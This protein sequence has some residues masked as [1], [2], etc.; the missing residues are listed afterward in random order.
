MRIQRSR[1]RG[2][3]SIVMESD[4]LRAVLL[5]DIGG[6][7]AS[8]LD[9]ETG[10]EYLWQEKTNRL[11]TPEY[12]TPFEEWAMFGFDEMFP[13]ISECHYEKKPWQ[14][15]KLP[16]HGEVWS[17]AWDYEIHEDLLHMWVYGVRLPYR[18]DKWIRFTDSRVIRTDYKAA[19]P[20]NFGFQFIW[21]AHPLFNVERGARIKLPQSVKRII[22]TDG[23]RERLGGYG[24][25]HAWP[26]TA[27]LTGEE[28]EIDRIY[29]NVGMN[30]EKY[31][32]L[33]ALDEGW[34]AVYNP[35]TKDAVALSFP[36]EKVPYLGLWVNEG[37]YHGQYNVAL[38]P[39]TGA[40]DRVDIASKCDRISVLPAKGV[41]TWH[42]GLTAGQVE[43]VRGVDPDG[44]LY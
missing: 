18:L 12:D 37:G 35:E 16:D 29:P 11:R 9:K 4:A 38:E 15:I 6:K 25:V 43:A 33:D 44:R 17:L 5:P 10:R 34:A 14:G 31:Y 20:S 28:Y 39:C 1:Y 32:V 26:K 22:N 36:L 27:T 30:Y 8:L 2:V 13:T 42:L 19:N 3:E 24:E 40:F 21:A 7:M 41:H 23:G